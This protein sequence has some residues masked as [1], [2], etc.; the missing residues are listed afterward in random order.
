FAKSAPRHRWVSFPEL[1][2][3]EGLLIKQWVPFSRKCRS[4]TSST[5]DRGSPL[6]ASARLLYIHRVKS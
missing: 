5:G 2:R 1:T 4:G 3:D 6:G